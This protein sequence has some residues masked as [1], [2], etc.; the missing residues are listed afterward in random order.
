MNQN[1]SSREKVEFI[2]L[3][4]KALHHY[5][6]S[7]DRIEKALFVVSEKLKID[8]NYFSL[9]TGIF[10]NFKMPNND[11]F[12]SMERLEPGKINLDKLSVADQTVDEVLDG[13]VT[14]AEGIEILNEVFKRKPRFRDLHVNISLFFLAFG[15]AIILK[16][17]LLDA[18]AAGIFGIGSGLF[19]S[20]VKTERIDTIAEAII[21]FIVSFCAFALP[22]FGFA[23]SPSVVILA[24]LIYFIP[25]LNLTM[26]IHEI[27]SQ[28]LTSGTARLTGAIIIMLKIS[29]GSYIGAE[30]AQGLFPI[31]FIAPDSSLDP[32]WIWPTLVVVPL[33]FVVLF[34]ANPRDAFWI[35]LGGF[36]SFSSS[37]YCSEQFGLI[38]GAFTS[39]VIIGAGSNMF[40][41]VMQRPAMIVLMPAIILLVPG[42]IGYKG[43]NFLFTQN[44]ID[45]I[46]TLFNSATIGMG[47]VAGA[48]FG[49]I[50]V[51]PK[52]SL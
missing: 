19:T 28:N 7:A 27:S 50:L 3:M 38:A 25:G 8:G 22:Y 49:N 12:T 44:T 29:F 52:R 15:I 2:M 10:A 17:S 30:V 39:G 23:I 16:G 34:Q 43:L 18:L 5:G 11:E 9:P 46:N 42:S 32:L 26:A 13:K 33:T 40:A 20:A 35:M 4:A 6:A 47:L 41:R 21:A 14:L 24:A 45:G 31:E 37:T 36:I 48:Y 1:A 51:K